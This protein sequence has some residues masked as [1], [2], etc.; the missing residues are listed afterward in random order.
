V[1]TFTSAGKEI[2]LH[3][4]APEAAS[5][6]KVPAVIVVHG[7]GGGG[8]Y[9][10]YYGREFTKLGYF[11]FI[12]HYF[13]STS[14][15][16]AQPHLI[17]KHFLTWLQTL[18]D[19]VSYVAQHPR[20]DPARIALLG[21]SLGAYLSTSLAAQDPRIAAVVDIF[22]GI[23][24]ELAPTVRRMPPTLILHGDADGI[25]PVSEADHLESVLKRIGAEH[26]K[27]ILSGQ[28][29]GFRGPAQIQAAMAVIDFLSRQLAAQAAYRRRS[30][31]ITLLESKRWHDSTSKPD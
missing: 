16:Y 9:F 27:M 11:V 15:G 13:D 17:Q 3:E 6:T 18:S 24:K 1:K 4:F 14:T 5:N 29:H 26:E 21:I 12:V 31:A 2:T 25:V 10:E 22:G 20:V 30:T 28:G 8:S 19:C 7:S 23:P